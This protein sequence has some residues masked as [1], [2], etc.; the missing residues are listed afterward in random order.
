[1]PIVRGC[2]PVSQGNSVATFDTC[3]YAE[4]VLDQ[5]GNTGLPPAG[6]LTPSG[7]GVATVRSEDQ[8]PFPRT[9]AWRLRCG[10]L[11]PRGWGHLEGAEECEDREDSP[12]IVLCFWKMQLH[13]DAAHVLLDRRLGH[14]QLA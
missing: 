9:D 14:P 8:V 1:M 10:R 13:E 7:G 2:A 6:Q 11:S 3:Q 5:R 4:R 12:M